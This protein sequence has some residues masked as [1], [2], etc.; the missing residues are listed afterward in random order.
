M[1]HLA[2]TGQYDFFDHNRKVAKASIPD[3]AATL[4][5]DRAAGYVR[6]TIPRSAQRRDHSYEKIT[7]YRPLGSSVS[8]LD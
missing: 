2:R 3:S 1:T 8:Q 7:N 5:P 4:S 6:F